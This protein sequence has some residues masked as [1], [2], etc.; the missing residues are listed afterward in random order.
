MRTGRR[1]LSEIFALCTWYRNDLEKINGSSLASLLCHFL[2]PYISDASMG[3]NSKFCYTISTQRYV[4]FHLP[5]FELRCSLLRR[6]LW[7]FTHNQ[8]LCTPSNEN[9][10]GTSDWHKTHE[11]AWPHTLMYIRRF[12]LYP[13][14]WHY[15]RLHR[16]H[17]WW[18]QSA[19]FPC[20]SRRISLLHRKLSNVYYMLMLGYKML[21]TSE[22]WISHNI[23]KFQGK[24]G[25]KNYR[26]CNRRAPKN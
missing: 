16:E 17:I 15:T 9:V 11:I 10:L 2:S 13:S 22:A 8:K 1:I 26:G 18:E 23:R 14:T 12:P 7:I 4:S 5:L 3:H 24:N 19:R 6:K 20:N 25:C 21:N